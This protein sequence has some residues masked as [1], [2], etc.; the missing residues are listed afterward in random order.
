M[1]TTVSDPICSLPTHLAPK[2]YRYYCPI[3]GI[4]LAVSNYDTPDGDYYCP[5]CSTP[6]GPSR[7]ATG[8]SEVPLE[9]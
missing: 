5:Y 8:L 1:S 7:V 3:C 6:Q 9:P 4:E 2:A